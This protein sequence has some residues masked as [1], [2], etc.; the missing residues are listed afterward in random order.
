[1][2]K[3][4][5]I[6]PPINIVLD[7]FFTSYKPAATSALRRRIEL[8]RSDLLTHLEL[9]GPRILTAGQLALLATEK[10]F[11]PDGAF[12][13]TGHADD[14]YYALEHYLIPAH[15]QAGLDQRELQLDVV[16]ALAA[17]LWA[18][19]LISLDTVSECCVIEFELAMKAARALV[20]DARLRERTLRVSSNARS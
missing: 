10:Q 17:K 6:H 13:R 7:D 9:E 11:N 12:A 18:E 4:T 3:I 2:T 5:V 1:M 19:R 14:L 16:A 8:V 20:S 15:A